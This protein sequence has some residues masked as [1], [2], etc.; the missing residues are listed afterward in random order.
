MKMNIF[1]RC[2]R[3]PVRSKDDIVAGLRALYPGIQSV[4]DD[5]KNGCVSLEDIDPGDA[6]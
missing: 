4:R 5:A 2:R 6:V 1:Q 3:E